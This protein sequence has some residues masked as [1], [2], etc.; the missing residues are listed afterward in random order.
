VVGDNGTIMRST[1]RGST[2]SMPV[3]GTSASLYAV[4]FIDGNNGWAVGDGGTIL[5]T[6]DGGETWAPQSSGTT[7]GL[8]GVAFTDSEH[9][10]AVGGVVKYVGQDESV[11]LRTIDGGTTWDNLS[12]G[13]G[14]CGEWLTSVAFR[15]SAVGFAVGGISYLG[16]NGGD[17][18]PVLLR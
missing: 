7:S 9:G 2:W 16:C 4:C 15:N 13:S 18:E 17:I 10:V 5:R 3:S 1:D 14:D 11:I 12:N 8:R 6:T